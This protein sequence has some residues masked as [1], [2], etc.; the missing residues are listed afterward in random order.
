LDCSIPHYKVISTIIDVSTATNKKTS[1]LLYSI[2]LQQ[3]I[4]RNFKFQGTPDNIDVQQLRI[5]EWK[6]PTLLKQNS[7]N[8]KIINIKSSVV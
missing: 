4:F 1:I 3:V 2:L 6:E 7:I 8:K 5:K